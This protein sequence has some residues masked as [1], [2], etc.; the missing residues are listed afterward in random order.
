MQEL[1]LS[2]ETERY[3]ERQGG[4][5][6]L[7]QMFH[8]SLRCRCSRWQGCCDSEI[9]KNLSVLEEGRGKMWCHH[10][11]AYSTVVNS[12]GLGLCVWTWVLKHHVECGE[13]QA[14]K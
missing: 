10:T 1:E 6:P 14:E 7:T 13:K 3:L 12:D 4:Q 9:E 8:F 5:D 2:L 11:M